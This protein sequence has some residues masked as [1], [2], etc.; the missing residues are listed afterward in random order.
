MQRAKSIDEIYGAVKDFDIVL[1]VDA[2]LATALNGRVDKPKIGGF[3]YT[4]K[5]IAAM[6]AVSQFG[7]GALSDIEMISIISEETDYNFKFVHSELENIRNIRKYTADVK[8]YLYSKSSKNIYESFSA[9]ETVEKAMELFDAEKN[10]FFE[11]KNVAVIGMELFNDLD[12]HFIK[13][14]STEIDIFTDGEYSIEKIFEVGNDRQLAENAVD[15]IDTESATDTAIVMDTNGPIADAV[16][17]A[18]YRRGIPFKNTMTVRDLSQIRDYLQFLQLSLSF[19]TLRIKHIRELFV[20]YGGFLRSEEDRYLLSKRADS[21]TSDKAREI[22]VLMRNVSNLTFAEVCDAVVEAKHQ[23]QVKMLLKGLGAENEKVTHQRVNEMVYAVNNVSDLHHNE[24]IPDSEKKGVLLADCCKSV[25]VD[26]PFVIYLGLG[27]EWAPAIVGKEYVDREAEADNNALR[28]KA[29][30]QQGTSRVYAVNSMRD[31]QEAR[32]SPIFEQVFAGETDDNGDQK[33]IS[34]FEDVCNTLIKGR[35]FDIEEKTYPKIRE[36]FVEENAVSSWRFSKSSYN[37]YFKCPLAFMFADFLRSPDSDATVFGSIL[38]EFAEFY[39]CYP[40]I[41][42]ENGTDHYAKAMEEI[43]SGLSNAQMKNVDSSRIKVCMNN[44]VRYID[45]LGITDPPLDRDCSRRKYKNSFMEMHGCGKYSSFTET[46]LSSGKH[47]LFGKFDLMFGSSIVD[48]KTGKPHKVDE[49][50]K[51]MDMGAELINY[52]FQP[53]IYLYL[54]KESGA[55]PPW[56]FSLFYAE[57]ND[58]ASVGEEFWINSNVR[59]VELLNEGTGSFLKG[60]VVR[61]H[62]AETK[63]YAKFIPKWDEFIDA[64]ISAGLD[65]R[66]EWDKDQGLQTTIA[67]RLGLTTKTDIGNIAGALKKLAKLIG[68]GIISIGGRVY[69]PEDA[70]DGFLAKVDEDHEAA[71]AGIC[72]EFIAKPGKNCSS[73]YFYKACTRCE[74]EDGEETADE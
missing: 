10:E 27:P 2:A 20:S 13:M 35:W 66:T 74:T 21:F 65:A 42:K 3:A 11:G 67:G 63:A 39:L 53:M 59:T 14:D 45:S 70:M 62:F 68:S 44:L 17:S 72:S 46:E 60:D 36:D 6:T 50:K 16:R 26:R 56:T 9:L 30:L 1:T 64:V 12:K 25:Y 52:E 41:V 8:K 61:Y 15:L 37:S 33:K 58:V 47:P 40:D 22:A 71:S 69:I 32:P 28:F 55:P 43:Y 51:S 31:G 38:H 24:Q 4:P 34:G 19:D 49:I 73:C 5:L 48:Y 23:P 7:K 29:L 18:L 57:D 54:L